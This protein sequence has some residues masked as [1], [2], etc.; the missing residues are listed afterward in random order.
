MGVGVPRTYTSACSDVRPCGH[1]GTALSL[2]EEILFLRLNQA[3]VESVLDSTVEGG[4]S[5]LDSGKLGFVY[6]LS[7]SPKQM[8]RACGSSSALR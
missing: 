3:S 1:L 6:E 8:G 5:A 7:G 4:V 2:T